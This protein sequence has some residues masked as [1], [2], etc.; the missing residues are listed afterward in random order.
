M[1]CDV[2]PA[3]ALDDLDAE[4]R[5]LLIRCD[6]VPRHSRSPAEGDHL[7]VFDKQH[8]LLASRQHA[9]MGRLLQRPRLAI[10]HSTEILNMIP[11]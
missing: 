5:Q 1:E 2:A 3:V 4:F 10:S 6:Q 9:G 11:L 8:P 7:R